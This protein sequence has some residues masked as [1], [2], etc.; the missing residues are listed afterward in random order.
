MSYRVGGIEYTDC[1]ECFESIPVYG[2]DGGERCERCDTMWCEDCMYEQEGSR[3]VFTYKNEKR[4]T[5]CTKSTHW[6]CTRCKPGECASKKCMRVSRL[7]YE[8]DAEYSKGLCCK[9]SSRFGE[10]CLGCFQHETRHLCTLLIGL[11]KFRKGHLLRGVPRDILIQCIV[12]PWL[13]NP[14]KG[15][16]SARKK[17]KI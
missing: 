3:H 5:A 10:K 4:C 2:E 14:F 13:V 12:I 17:L 9:H 15:Q 8:K 11:R 6:K 16:P 1:D 7:H